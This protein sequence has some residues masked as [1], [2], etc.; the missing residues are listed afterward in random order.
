MSESITRRRL[1]EQ[2]TQLSVAAMASA[3]LSPA[4]ARAAAAP[5]KIKVGQIG[6]GHA[7][8][9]KL[10]VYRRSPDYEVVGVVEPDASLRERAQSVAAYRDVPWLSEQQLLETPGLQAVLVETQV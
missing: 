2:A 9:T 8:A 1:L 3:C 5:P 6:T 7:H 10:E 4:T